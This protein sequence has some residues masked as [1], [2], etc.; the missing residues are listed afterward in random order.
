MKILGD[1]GNTETKVCLV[2]S[3]NRI[4]KK[5]SLTYHKRKYELLTVRVFGDLLNLVTYPLRQA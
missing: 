3:N 4:I 5:I 1:I 2:S